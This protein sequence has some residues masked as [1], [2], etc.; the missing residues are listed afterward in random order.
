M[1]ISLNKNEINCIRLNVNPEHCGT[2]GSFTA[3]EE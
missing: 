3:S 2:P 1:T